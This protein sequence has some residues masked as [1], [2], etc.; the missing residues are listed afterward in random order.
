[1]SLWKAAWFLLTPNIHSY[2]NGCQPWT[3][4][5]SVWHWSKR[6]HSDNFCH[7]QWHR[8]LKTPG[9]TSLRYMRLWDVSCLPLSSAGYQK[10]SLPDMKTWHNHLH[11]MLK[12]G[13]AMW[14]QLVNFWVN[15]WYQLSALSTCL[16]QKPAA[17]QCLKWQLMLRFQEHWQFPPLTK[18]AQKL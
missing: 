1:M 2:E 9:C 10:A 4:S 12:I 18:T 5:T 6:P 13:A 3:R 7:G 15:M 16:T 14:V 8:C 17:M 11:A